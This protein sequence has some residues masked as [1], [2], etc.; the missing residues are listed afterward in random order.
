MIRAQAELKENSM[1]PSSM[2]AI[3]GH[4]HMHRRIQ[5]IERLFCARCFI[6]LTCTKTA[7]LL[8]R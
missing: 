7:D 6:L 3:V 5:F 2:G 8:G 4:I 1:C